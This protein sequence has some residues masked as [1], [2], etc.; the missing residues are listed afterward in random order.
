M[1]KSANVVQW[2]TTPSLHGGIIAG[3]NPA[4]RT[5][6]VVGYRCC[7]SIQVL[8]TCGERSTRS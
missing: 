8:G 5:S 6:L 2:P 4:V 7:G 1:V 3:S